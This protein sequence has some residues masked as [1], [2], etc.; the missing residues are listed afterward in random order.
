MTE[1]TKISLKALK[2][3][4]SLSNRLYR[5]YE[6]KLSDST[7]ECLKDVANDLTLNVKEN[8][9]NIIRDELDN[10]GIQ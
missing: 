2:D 10:E 8:I 7:K 3:V 5:A 4:V 6:D 1:E 9:I